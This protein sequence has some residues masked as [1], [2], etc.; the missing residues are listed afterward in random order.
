M[1]QR[2][3]DRIEY[4]QLSQRE[5]E[6]RK[7]LKRAEQAESEKK[8]RRKRKE[9]GGSFTRRALQ[10]ENKLDT[11]EKRSQRMRRSQKIRTDF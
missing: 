8:E 11:N 2:E 9:K 3:I 5:R 6:E 10:R 1:N 4:A 7:L